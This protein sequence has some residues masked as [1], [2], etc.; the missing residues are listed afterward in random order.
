MI[1]TLRL[2]DQLF[3]TRVKVQLE[4]NDNNLKISQRKPT[5]TKEKERKKEDAQNV[6]FPMSIIDKTVLKSMLIIVVI[7]TLHVQK[8]RK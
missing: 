2:M 7:L 6:Q 1:H 3:T 5:P 8:Q 4:P